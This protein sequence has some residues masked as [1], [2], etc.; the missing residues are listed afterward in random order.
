MQKLLLCCKPRL[1]S[2]LALQ[3]TDLAYV[4]SSYDVSKTVAGP[5][6]CM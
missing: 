6:L 5:V 4:I 3:A 1:S 2:L